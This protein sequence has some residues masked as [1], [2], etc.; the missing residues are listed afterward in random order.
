MGRRRAPLS[1]AGGWRDAAKDR[2]G[3]WSSGSWRGRKAQAPQRNPGLSRPRSRP[4]DR[5]LMVRLPQQRSVISASCITPRAGA[6]KL[7]MPQRGCWRCDTLPC[8]LERSGWIALASGTAAEQAPRRPWTGWPA[9]CLGLP[10]ACRRLTLTCSSRAACMGFYAGR[11]TAA[12]ADLRVAIR[13]ARHGAAAAQL[14]RAHVQLCA[15]VAE[16]RGVGRSAR[17]CP[18]GLVAGVGR[19]AGLD[20]R[21]GARHAGPA[22]RRPGRVAASRR[23]PGRGRRRGG[24]GRARSRRRSPLAS[25]RQRWR[26]PATIRSRS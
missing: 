16:L 5:G 21:A 24:R 25:R 11:T 9:G 22:V 12:I 13:L 17:A 10:R 8:E 14:P 2:C 26:G 6:T 20:G 18:G 4:A 15:A 23:A 3:A 7:S 1:F 19:T